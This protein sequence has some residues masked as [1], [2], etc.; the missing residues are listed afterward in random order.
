MNPIHLYAEENYKYAKTT[1]NIRDRPNIKGKIIG[2]IYW[3]E[4]IRTIKKV[5]K[6]WYL[7]FYKKKKGYICSKYLRKSR[8]EYKAYYP[9][10]K[11]TFKSYEDADCITDNNNHAQ[12]RLKKKYHLDCRSGIW[13]VGNRYCIAVGS[14]YTK[15]IGAKI[16]LV[17]SHNGRKHV[18]KCIA[19]DSKADKDTIN[20]H[21]IHT[22]GSV[23]EFIVN[24]GC[25]SKKVRQMG[26]VSF[27]GDKFKGE[28]GQIRVYG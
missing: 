23:V 1:V 13:M 12:G 27:A 22:D 15:Q 2:Q 20:K 7:A 17:L 18:L 8:A 10:G 26:D 19:A 3:N 24:T 5:N 25:L 6:E 21:R 11:S 28:I 9:P 4:K 14:Y 16:D